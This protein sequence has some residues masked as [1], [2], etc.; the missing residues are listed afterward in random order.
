VDAAAGSTHR[1]GPTAA[2]STRAERRLRR[3]PRADRRREGQACFPDL[4]RQPLT[5]LFHLA[6]SSG[7]ARRRA[8]EIL[9]RGDKA[10]FAAWP[11]DS[12]ERRRR[13]IAA[14][15]RPPRFSRSRCETVGA[16]EIA[17]S[18]LLWIWPIASASALVYP[19]IDHVTGYSLQAED[20]SPAC[21][22]GDVWC[23]NIC[24]IKCPDFGK[25]STKGCSNTARSSLGVPSRVFLSRS[26][27]AC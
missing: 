16:A 9:H 10:A 2:S 27:L 15:A 20:P 24:V 23:A 3:P 13:M 11:A 8:A 25:T 12:S 5:T 26:P 17:T 4:A 21:D 7:V 1:P 22:G 14:R 19:P 18:C 6:S